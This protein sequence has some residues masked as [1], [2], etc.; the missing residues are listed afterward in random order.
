MT[1]AA[2]PGG[3]GR[4]RNYLAGADRNTLFWRVMPAGLVLLLVLGWIERA[5]FR[6]PPALRS[7][8]IDTTLAAARGPRPGAGEVLIEAEP[9]EVTAG[10][11]PLSAAPAA[12]AA[13]RDATFFR[14]AETNAWLQTW[15]TLESEDETTRRG[16]AASTPSFSELFGQPRSFRGR[17]VRLRG[18]FHRLEQVRAPANDDG[19]EDFWQGWLELD[20]GPANPVVVQCL[21]LP[22]GMPTG[23][24]IRAA[25]EVVGYFFKNWA[26]AAADT[27]RV[28]PLVM[29]REPLWRPPPSP[30]GRGF[31]SLVTAVLATT[32]VLVAATWF[33]MVAAGRRA[34]R[35][36]ASPP[37]DLDAALAGVETFSV[38][39]SLR[40][41]AEPGPATGQGSPPS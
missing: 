31:D 36:D 4:P 38:D 40:R 7:P 15:R 18:V 37:P 27:V 20:G 9:E 25:A 19:I 12:L 23:M 5:W 17:L 2:G 22:A 41:L 10:V 13:V 39:E 30:A 32:V 28:A 29:T 14:A 21:R 3:R 33:G 8:P 16:A 6:A 1:R 11:E 34:G 24:N 35:R 26:Y